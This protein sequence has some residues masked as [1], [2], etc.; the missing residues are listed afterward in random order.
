MGKGDTSKAASGV[1]GGGDG[2]M[3]ELVLC[4]AGIFFFY[5]Q[6]SMAQHDMYT[7]Q[8][9]NTIFSHTPL[10]LF[11]MI[12]TNVLGAYVANFS[13]SRVMGTSP[14]LSN[15]PPVFA[16]DQLRSGYSWLSIGFCFYAAMDASNRS[17]ERLPYPIMVLG[18]SCKMVPV[19]FA[20]VFINKTKYA[21]TKYASV[22]IVTAGLIFV[23][24]SGGGGDGEQKFEVFPLLLLLLSLTLDAVV[25]PRQEYHRDV[26]KK[27]G[28]PLSPWETMLKTNLGGV[29]W[30]R[31]LF[32]GFVTVFVVVVV[33]VVAA[34]AVGV[35]VVGVVVDCERA[36]LL[37][38]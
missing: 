8:D 7:R 3:L 28:T 13:L 19:M 10:L 25:G 36:C 32:H 23:N 35:V 20:G 2:S 17:L 4:S 26:C 22:F 31:A 14:S 30:V 38:V 27:N 6:F 37:L 9:D 11:V 34:A 16:L 12:F 29:V 18:K 15:S 5:F 21:W 33:V 24:F 1:S